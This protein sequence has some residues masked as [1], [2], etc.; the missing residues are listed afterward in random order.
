MKKDNT[1]DTAN[2][3]ATAILQKE[4]CYSRM[5]LDNETTRALPFPVMVDFVESMLNH[6]TITLSA[7]VFGEGVKQSLYQTGGGNIR[8]KDCCLELS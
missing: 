8:K 7:F 6:T 2:Q 1:R 3:I 5:A 4:H